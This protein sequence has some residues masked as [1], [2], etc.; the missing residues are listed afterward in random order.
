MDT[1]ILQLFAAHEILAQIARKQLTGCFKVFTPVESSEVYFKNG[2]VVA[3]VK[4]K[5]GGEEA[6]QQILNWKE[7]L[8]LW[9]PNNTAPATLKPI[10][11]KIEDFL[12]RQTA[13]PEPVSKPAPAAKAA[14]PPSSGDS[15]HS[16][17]TT[18]SFTATG[19]TRS[20]LDE[21]LL[22]KHQ[23]VLVSLDSPTQKFKIV[24]VKSI[25][26]RNPGSDIPIPDA[27]VSR[28]HCLLQIMDRGLHVKDLN[29]VNGTKVNGV[30]TKEGYVNVG[31]KLTVGHLRFTLERA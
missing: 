1:S 8:F 15:T 30:V 4:G 31:D 21:K 2:E 5:L 26:G 13:S 12:S 14:T 24:Q 3:A 17:A 20:S 9:K 28:Q 16:H 19:E 27:S 11:I 7:A 6:L 25:V 29:T 10:Q 18:K 22:Q 23:L